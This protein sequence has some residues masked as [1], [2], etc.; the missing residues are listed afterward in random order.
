MVPPRR[1]ARPRARAEQSGVSFYL[2]GWGVANEPIQ[3]FLW[4]SLAAQQNYPGATRQR[5]IAERSLS[6][7]ELREAEALVEQWKPEIPQ[8]SLAAP[9]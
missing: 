1:R 8:V 6:R 3:A 7:G 2:R 9:D 4:S 5:M